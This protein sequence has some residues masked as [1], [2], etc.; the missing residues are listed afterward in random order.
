MRNITVSCDLNYRGK[1]WSSDKAQNIMKKLMPYVDVC[2]GNEEDA[3]KSLG[4]NTVRND[5]E[6]GKLNHEG[7][8]DVAKRI[9]DLYGCRCVAITL[10]ES[11]SASENGWSGML[12]SN[13]NK[14][15]YFSKKYNIQIVDRVGSGD[16]FTAGL[17]YGLINNQIEQDTIEFAVAASCLKHSIEG[18]FN[19]ISVE[20]VNDLILKGG[21]G[22]VQR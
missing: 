19:R 2:I 9:C 1:L 11:Y 15:A 6:S 7:Y 20:E 4:I 5:I 16:S 14:Q 18:D 12:Y 10:R 13:T 21:N 3:D 17:I 22:R 8:I